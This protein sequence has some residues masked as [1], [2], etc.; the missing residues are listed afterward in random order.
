MKTKL[1]YFSYST[2]MVTCMS[3]ALV[4]CSAVDSDAQHTRSLHANQQNGRD[5]TPNENTNSDTGAITAR[6]GN[7]AIVEEFTRAKSKGTIAAFEL[8][9]ARH[10]EHELVAE[11]QQHIQI[12]RQ[13]LN[14][15]KEE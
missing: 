7:I 10:P 14:Q 12:L 4:S 8:F 15:R 13:A 3:A 6:D 1:S 11:A 9:I 5:M 2:L